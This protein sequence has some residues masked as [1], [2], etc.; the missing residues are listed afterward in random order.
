MRE[1][2]TNTSL[3][4]VLLL[5]SDD[6]GA[7]RVDIKMGAEHLYIGIFVEDETAR[8]QYAEALPMLSNAL[9][10]L[11]KQC[12]CRVDIDPALV[13]DA[14]KE[15]AMATGKMRLDIRV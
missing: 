13:Q 10:P 9:S 2:E 7:V 12:Y 5:N 14:A 4:A 1:G 6:R 8:R 3:T 15:E 11:T